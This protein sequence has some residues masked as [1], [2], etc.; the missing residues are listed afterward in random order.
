MRIALLILFLSFPTV[1]AHAEEN[2][3][4]VKAAFVLNFL[5][6]TQTQARNDQSPPVVCVFGGIAGEEFAP[7]I[8]SAQIDGRTPTLM[9]DPSAKIRPECTTVFIS[10]EVSD[11]S[12]ILAY[13]HQRGVLLIGERED[14]LKLGGHV[15]FYVEE[16]RIHFA[17]R[18]NL[19]ASDGI[20]FSA[21]LLALARVEEE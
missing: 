20:Q 10:S 19:A 21:K 1:S 18:R 7:I 5:K 3:Y 9:I 16:R 11:P 12:P 2:E 14:F 13:F 6:L 15:L 17:I 4:K 8:S